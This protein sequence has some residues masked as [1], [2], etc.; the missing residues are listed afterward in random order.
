M[1]GSFNHENAS[2]SPGKADRGDN[3][4]TTNRGEK[5]DV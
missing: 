5:N 3:H 1:W 2:M 4:F